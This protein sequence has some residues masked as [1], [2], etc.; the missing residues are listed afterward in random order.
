MT[1]ALTHLAIAS[2]MIGHY[3]P[4]NADAY[5]SFTIDDACEAEYRGGLVRAARERKRAGLKDMFVELP[6]NRAEILSTF[7][8]DEYVA[9]HDWVCRSSTAEPFEVMS[10][11]S[12]ED[13]VDIVFG[14][15][16]R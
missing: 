12:F 14:E 6:K 8:L 7:E 9:L 10:I 4:R 1:D 2:Q 3:N 16:D 13:A 11:C 15:C 5:V